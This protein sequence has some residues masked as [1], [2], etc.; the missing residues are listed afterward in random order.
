MEFDFVFLTVVCALG[1]LGGLLHALVFGQNRLRL[2]RRI[3]RTKSWDLTFLGDIL[4]GVG[5]AVA[6]LYVVSPSDFQKLV[7]LSIFAGFSGGS[8]LGSFG[9]RTELHLEREKSRALADI[10]RRE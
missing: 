8:V 2:P 4:V 1:A 7:S 10:V 3:A 9:M 5:A 6:V